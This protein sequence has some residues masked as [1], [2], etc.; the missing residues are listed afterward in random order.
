MGQNTQRA[1]IRLIGVRAAGIVGPSLGDAVVAEFD[2]AILHHASPGRVDETRHAG[3]G[4]PAPFLGLG[5]PR[6]AAESTLVAVAIRLQGRH[7]ELPEEVLSRR[8]AA[9]E[10]SHRSG[11]G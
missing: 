8:Y 4:D 10:S 3:E 7:A 2:A 9:D 1:E 11:V 6:R 5:G